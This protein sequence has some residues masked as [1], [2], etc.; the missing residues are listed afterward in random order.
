MGWQYRTAVLVKIFFRACWIFCNNPWLVICPLKSQI[1][2][3][4]LPKLK[5]YKRHE[6]Y[7]S[8]FFFTFYDFLSGIL[9]E[10]FLAQKFSSR[11]H[12]RNV[13]TISNQQKETIKIYIIYQRSCL[14][15]YFYICKLFSYYTCIIG[16][17]NIL[18]VHS[19]IYINIIQIK[20]KKKGTDDQYSIHCVHIPS[21]FT[22]QFWPI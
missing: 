20:T 9:T 7:N 3:Y 12:L 22:C 5:I 18:K 11:S 16:L 17:S 13:M 15:L 21:I 2:F 6:I 14:F 8:D 10:I 1:F 19:F 4:A